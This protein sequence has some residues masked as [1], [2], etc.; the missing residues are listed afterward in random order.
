MS[1]LNVLGLLISV[2]GIAYYNV[3]KA[4]EAKAKGLPGLVT[5]LLFYFRTRES[6]SDWLGSLRFEICRF[7]IPVAIMQLQSVCP[8]HH[9]VHL[10]IRHPKNSIYVAL[11]V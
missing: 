8:P 9:T 3:I 10:G 11:C 1:G 7:Q 6:I 5:L 4:R 2:A